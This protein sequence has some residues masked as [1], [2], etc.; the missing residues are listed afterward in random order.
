MDMSKNDER[1]VQID[2]MKIE[3]IQTPALI[4]DKKILLE[5]IDAMNTMLKGSN[6][7][8]RPHYKSHKCDYLAHLQIENGAKGMTCAK[9]SEAIDLVDSGI[10]DILIANQIVDDKKIRRLAE[11]AGDCRLTVCVDDINN[12]KKLSEAAEAT[13]NT[14]YCLVEFEIGM[15]RCGVSSKQEVL[16]L[17]ELIEK[18][19]NLVFDGL[20][21]YAGHISHIEDLTERKE[22][23]L[24]NYKKIN[25]V[26]TF[27]NDNNI[28]VNVISGG[29]TGTSEIKVKE[30]LYNELQAGSYLFMDATYKNLNLPFKNSLFILST[31]VS[32]RNGLTVIDSGVK[33]CGID[34]GMPEVVDNKVEF[35]VASEEHFQLHGLEKNL[36]V[37]EKVKLIPGHCCSTVNLHDKIYLVDG[38]KVVDRIL[39][40][41]KGIGR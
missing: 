28:A 4:L 33:T 8:L 1:R 20:Q 14:I 3:N 18:S 15:Q 32:K 2:K 38:D 37:G 16:Q 12:I 41:A 26:I 40:T 24:N 23:T 9:I 11:L 39:I 7:R 25:D 31:V 36:E 10:E 19:N 21:V 6:L 34:Q 29:S 35:I 5:N 17:A 22:A 30:G 13:G 27:L